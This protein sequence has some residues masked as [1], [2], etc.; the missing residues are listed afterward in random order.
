MCFD[1]YAMTQAVESNWPVEQLE[2]MAHALD[3]GGV[4]TADVMT[5][6]RT[7]LRWSYAGADAAKPTNAAFAPVQLGRVTTSTPMPGTACWC[8]EWHIRW[9]I[10]WSACGT[11]QPYTGLFQLLDHWAGRPELSPHH[12]PP[13][14]A[15]S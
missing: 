1:V 11:A 3:C 9:D 4:S 14:G 8:Y 5:M 15:K 13:L 10:T 6:V 7:A 12:I 2:G